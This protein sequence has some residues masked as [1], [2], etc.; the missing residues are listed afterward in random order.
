MKAI[1]CKEWGSPETYRVK[2][3]DSMS[4]V[5]SVC[6]FPSFIQHRVTPVKMG[7]RYSLVGW[8]RG[9]MFK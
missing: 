8:F 3:L 9:D 7:T 5:G 6:V 2:T 1:V 4:T